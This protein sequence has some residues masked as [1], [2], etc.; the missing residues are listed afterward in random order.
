MQ[1]VILQKMTGKKLFY[2]FCLVRNHKIRLLNFFKK[3]TK[4]HQ[5]QQFDILFGGNKNFQKS[6]EKKII[7]K[8]L[9]I[10]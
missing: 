8:L 9:V 5:K 1:K 10:K 7:R 6:Q 3:I 4:M 2:V